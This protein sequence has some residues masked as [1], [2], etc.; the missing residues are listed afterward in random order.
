MEQVGTDVFVYFQM[1]FIK[2]TGNK[3]NSFLKTPI[4]YSYAMCSTE[5]SNIS[6]AGQFLLITG[7]GT[8][9]DQRKLGEDG[10]TPST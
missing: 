10:M 1:K 5:A 7:A 9:R 8:Q 4:I 2:I 3:I 6:S